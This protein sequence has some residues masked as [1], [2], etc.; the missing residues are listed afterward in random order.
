M[1]LSRFLR[2]ELVFPDLE[3][4]DGPT[5]LRGLAKAI[6]AT[7]A[8]RDSKELAERFLEREELGSTAIGEGVAI[9]HCKLPGADRILVA[10]GRLPKGIDLDAPDGL[11]VTV[12]FAV[13]S[14]PEAP[15]EHLKC[16][17]AL[18]KWIRQDHNLEHLRASA[19][20]DEIYDHLLA[21]SESAP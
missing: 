13:V 11:P 20:R 1:Q 8:V 3:G 16:L 9:P 14:P 18:S 5:A 12:I 6:A 2:K 17:A 7:G 19:D 10:V 15:A 21:G 4:E